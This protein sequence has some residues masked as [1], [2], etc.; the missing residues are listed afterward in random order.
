MIFSCI[1]LVL[2]HA[3]RSI[4]EDCRKLLI[5]TAQC[6]DPLNLRSRLKSAIFC[7]SWALLGALQKR[8]VLR[9]GPASLFCE[10]LASVSSVVSQR[11]LYM[12]VGILGIRF[13]FQL[14]SL[15]PV[16][17]LSILASAF[18]YLSLSSGGFKNYRQTDGSSGI[19]FLLNFIDCW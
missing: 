17:Q 14:S 1:V 5:T 11:L 6:H 10:G 3:V 15:Q 2:D 18:Y 16:S 8:R 4:L 13:Y 9:K 12:L 19:W 7:Y